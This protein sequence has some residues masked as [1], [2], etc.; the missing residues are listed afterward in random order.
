MIE[1]VTFELGLKNKY[2][3]NKILRVHYFITES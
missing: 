1:I 3:F 2:N